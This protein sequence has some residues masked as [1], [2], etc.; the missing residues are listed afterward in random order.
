MKIEK[1]EKWVKKGAL[2]WQAKDRD[3][4]VSVTS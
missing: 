4:S 3:L 1:R 2:L